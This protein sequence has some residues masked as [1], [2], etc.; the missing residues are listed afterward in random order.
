MRHE[1]VPK[2]GGSW[3]YGATFRDNRISFLTFPTLKSFL[4]A[5]ADLNSMQVTPPPP[6]EHCPELFNMFT[7][8]MNSADLQGA[9]SLSSPT[10]SNSS[11]TTSR[12]A[13]SGPWP[14]EEE[15]FFRD[16][17]STVPFVVAKCPT[18]L[19]SRPS[20]SARSTPCAL[21]TT[22]AFSSLA[23]CDGACLGGV[24]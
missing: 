8:S 6:V 12:S 13:A 17:W 7:N 15:A 3:G 16:L 11:S 5:S 19:P 24:C 20:S 10:P 21:G 1:V 14:R 2:R 18:T 22:N 4:V 23:P 9:K